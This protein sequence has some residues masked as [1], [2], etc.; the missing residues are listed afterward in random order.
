MK[1]YVSIALALVLG[2]SLCACG[3]TDGAEGGGTTGGSTS[4]QY[5]ST[6]FAGEPFRLEDVLAEN[7]LT[8]VNVWGTWCTYCILEMPELEKL[9]QNYRE[10]DDK[11]A[12]I[13]LWTDV[14]EEE[15]C[16]EILESTGVTYPIVRFTDEM[17]K[18]IDT[19]MLPVTYF[20]DREGE[21]VGDVVLGARDEAEWEEII[22]ERLEQVRG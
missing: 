13:G 14:D 8:M 3:G 12:I 4:F 2:L 16:A 9:H 21:P 6:D 10:S 19:S 1:K 5:E 22:Q 18:A 11:V 15:E 7:E 20:V 17:G